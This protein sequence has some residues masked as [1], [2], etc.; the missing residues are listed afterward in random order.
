MMVVDLV[1]VPTGELVCL[2][3]E[4]GAAPAPGRAV[5]D[6]AEVR[7]PLLLPGWQSRERL[8]DQRL[9]PDRA[10]S[11]GVERRGSPSR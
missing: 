1:D 5:R 3:A 11:V 2:H 10:V 6:R 4:Q 7:R 8:A 9:R